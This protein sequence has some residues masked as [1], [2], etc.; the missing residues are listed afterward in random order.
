M[1]PPR[2]WVRRTPITATPSTLGSCDPQIRIAAALVNPTSIGFDIRYAMTPARSRP[3]EAHTALTLTASRAAR[4]TYSAMKGVAIV[5]RAP[6][7][8]RAVIATGP[9]CRYGDDAKI[10][11]AIGGSADA[12]SPM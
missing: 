3:I 12:N 8:S 11:A 10:A 9:V 1:G 6:N 4:A 2:R 7:V 5:E